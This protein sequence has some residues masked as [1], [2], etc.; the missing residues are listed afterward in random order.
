MAVFFGV[1]GLIAYYFQIITPISIFA[2]LIV[3]PLL[4]VIIA[5][6]L[7]LILVDALFPIAATYFAICIKLALNFLVAVVFLLEKVP[8]SHF[9]L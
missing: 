5:L 8:F 7:G 6:G 1:T 4:T 9:Y 3:I 2:N